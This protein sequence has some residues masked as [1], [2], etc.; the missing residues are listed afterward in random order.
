MGPV[1]TLAALNSFYELPQDREPNLKALRNFIAR[2]SPEEQLI[3]L[4]THLVTISAISGETVSSGEGVVLKLSPAA[5]FEVIGR[6]D[7]NK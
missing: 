6:L 1:T 5:S 2:Q 7:F 4:V 3:I